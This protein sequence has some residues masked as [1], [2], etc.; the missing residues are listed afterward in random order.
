MVSTR[1]L[2]LPST[3]VAAV[4]MP[5]ASSLKAFI[6]SDLSK[7]TRGV[8]SPKTHLPIKELNK[9]LGASLQPGRETAT[10]PRVVGKLNPT[11]HQ[12]GPL[13]RGMSNQTSLMNL[14]GRASHGPAAWVG[15]LKEGKKSALGLIALRMLWFGDKQHCLYPAS[16]SS[17]GMQAVF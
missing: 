7:F 14:R 10:N 8:F 6:I 12:S 5:P 2:L 15:A 16:V 3:S 9:R 13:P 1:A 4:W 11:F 17:S